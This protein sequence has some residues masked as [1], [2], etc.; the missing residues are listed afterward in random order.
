ERFA[1]ATLAGAVDGRPWA[2]LLDAAKAAGASAGERSLQGLAG[3]LELVPAKE[4]K[5]LEREGA[6]ARRR[7]ERRARTEALDVS[8]RVVELWLR[9]VLCIGEGA[10]ELV[11]AVDRRA[12]LDADAA[13]REGGSDALREA[14]ELVADTRLRL[15]LNVSEELALEA[16][17]Y[18]LAA[19]LSR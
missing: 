4:R 17:A 3:E 13:Q 12:E 5:R 1:R 16:L 9:D 15:A 8:L 11:H 14:I 18:R 19:K 6:D 10:S 2:A 7:V